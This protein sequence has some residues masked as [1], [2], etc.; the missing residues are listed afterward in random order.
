MADGRRV[1][2]FPYDVIG[3]QCLPSRVVVDECLEMSVQEI[4][5][6]RHRLAPLCGS[7]HARRAETR[8]RPL[9]SSSPI[10]GSVLSACTWNLSSFPFAAL[11]R[12]CFVTVCSCR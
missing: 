8:D 6:D 1:G 12:A 5:G 2:E 9:S 11:Q 7:C 10:A 3:D 4:G